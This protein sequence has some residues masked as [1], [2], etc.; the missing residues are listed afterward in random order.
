MEHVYSNEFPKIQRLQGGIL[1]PFCVR[2]VQSEDPERPP[3]SYEYRVHSIDSAESVSININ[4][5][6][7]FKTHIAGQLKKD[8]QQHIYQHYDN[9]AQ[10]TISGYAIRAL[11][12]NRPDVVAECRKMQDWIDTVLDYYDQK[13]KALMA[14]VSEAALVSILW[15]F[16]HEAPLKDYMGWRDAKQM[17]SVKAP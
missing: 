6:E 12:E 9:G 10:A 16:G 1:I 4:N 7:I 15:D 8:L 3:T 5:L 13:K 11:S 17:F 2:A 14:T